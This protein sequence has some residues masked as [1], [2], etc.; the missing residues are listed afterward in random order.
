MS[1]D[2]FFSYELAVRIGCP[3][4]Y[5]DIEDNFQLPC[6]E[7]RWMIIYRG[8]DLEHTAT[9]LIPY[10][11]YDFR[12]QVYNMVGGLSAPPVV[13]DTTLPAGN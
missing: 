4:P 6:E 12:L 2:F 3:Y 11:E 9:G 5:A 13:T 1:A 8:L 7:G 10:T